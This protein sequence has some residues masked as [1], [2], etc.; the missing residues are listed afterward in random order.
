MK[1]LINLSEEELNR[2]KLLLE[3]NSIDISLIRDIV[4]KITNGV[5]IKEKLFRYVYVLQL[6]D[7]YDGHLNPVFG[8]TLNETFISK[9]DAEQF[10]NE[11]YYEEYNAAWKG[12]SILKALQE[13]QF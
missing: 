13:V 6:I 11:N 9:K 2:L 1:L 10:V 3:N 7:G 5:E 8:D 4:E 12:I